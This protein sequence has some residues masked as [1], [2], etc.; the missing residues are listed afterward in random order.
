MPPRK[1]DGQGMPTGSM[2]VPEEQAANPTTDSGDRAALGEG[3]HHLN[4][5]LQCLRELRRHESRG[6]KPT[7]PHPQQSSSTPTEEQQHA[8]L[9]RKAQPARAYHTRDLQG[10][11]TSTNRRRWGTEGAAG[12][13]SNKWVSTNR[14][15]ARCRDNATA[16]PPR[17]TMAGQCPMHEQ[18]GTFLAEARGAEGEQALHLT[19]SYPNH[20]PLRSSSPTRNTTP[21]PAWGQKPVRWRSNTLRGAQRCTQRTRWHWRG[22]EEAQPSKGGGEW[23]QHEARIRQ[24]LQEALRSLDDWSRELW[25]SSWSWKHTPTATTTTHRACTPP[26][27]QRMEG[28]G[29]GTGRHMDILYHYQVEPVAGRPTRRTAQREEEGQAEE[30]G[31]R[32]APGPR[33]GGSTT[34]RSSGQKKVEATQAPLVGGKELDGSENNGD[35]EMGGEDAMQKRN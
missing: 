10:G 15:D 13:T 29:E 9:D 25:G 20:P 14:K 2:E 27:Y 8:A 4:T 7:N 3:R 31:D 21:K 1:K 23:L 18:L 22:G 6:A 30:R 16:R 34:R 17:A 28:R 32:A 11:G 24:Q 26:N 35:D 12:K 33:E 19:R 5:A